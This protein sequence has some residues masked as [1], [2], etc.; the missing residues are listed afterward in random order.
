MSMYARGMGDAGSSTLDPHAAEDR[1]VPEEPARTHHGRLG[2]ALALGAVR[3]ALTSVAFFA[4]AGGAHL[5]GAPTW[6][7]GALFG[8]CYLA[9]GWEPALAGL[10]ALGG[11]AAAR[12]RLVRRVGQPG[13]DLADLADHHIGRGGRSV[14]REAERLQRLSPLLAPGSQRGVSL[15]EPLLG[16]LAT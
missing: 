8:L 6:A 1:P 7:S 9:G 4:L 13:E 12:K 14:G 3:W 15:I 2:A 16:R 5:L 10:R 11:D